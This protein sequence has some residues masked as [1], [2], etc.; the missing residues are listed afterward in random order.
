MLAVSQMGR[1]ESWIEFFLLGVEE[2]SKDAIIRAQTLLDLQQT[3]RH[4]IQRARSSALLGRLI[5]LLFEHPALSV[6]SAAENLGISYNAAKNNIEI[7]IEHEILRP[8]TKSMR[9]KYFFAQQ[10]ID[11]MN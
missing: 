4:K 3:F 9:P 6:P 10:I 2:A 7:L 8:G 5:D 1:W 11:V